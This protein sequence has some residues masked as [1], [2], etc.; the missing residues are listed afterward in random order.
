MASK[1][2]QT[3]EV[4]YY[5]CDVNATMTLS[6]MIA[7]A[8]KVSEDQSDQ[9]N[10]GADFIHRFGLT[11]IVTNYQFFIQRLPKVGEKIQITTQAQSYNKY[12]CYRNFWL[13]TEAGEE[14]VRIETIFALMNMETR[15]MSSVPEEIIAPFE[16]EKVKKIQ[17]YPKIEKVV[18]GESYPFR[19]RFYDID[20][21][22]HV[23]NSVYFT[24]MLD[25]LG[26]DFLTT[27]EPTYMHIRFDKEVEYGNEIMS[28]FEIE[29]DEGM[30]TR[31]EIRIG[32]QTYCEANVEWRTKD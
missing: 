5:E 31:H 6:S 30:K 20:S 32:E 9:L 26:Y 27:H 15:K 3:H 16:S 17:R 11:W 2:T 4:T 29:T 14:L 25:A 18:A 13:T 8:I 7:V 22:Q 1:Y 21:N 24:W 12:F 28:H 23:N 10:R 19:V